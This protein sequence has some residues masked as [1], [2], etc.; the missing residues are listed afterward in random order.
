M[1]YAMQSMTLVADPPL[2]PAEQ[3]DPADELDPAE[4]LVE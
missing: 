4:H 2:D 3:L 1:T